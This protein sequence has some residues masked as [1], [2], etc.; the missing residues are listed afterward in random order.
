MRQATGISQN[1]KS[2]SG[3]TENTLNENR[4]NAL[5]GDSNGLSVFDY[6]ESPEKL[7][8]PLCCPTVSGAAK[9]CPDCQAEQDRRRGEIVQLFTTPF[10]VIKLTARCFSCNRGMSAARMSSGR[11]ICRTCADELKTKGATARN[12]FVEKVKANVGRFLKEVASV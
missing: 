7:Q 5:G 4:F 3:A 8:C 10:K 12:N 9:L 11:V 6:A 1:E 2:V